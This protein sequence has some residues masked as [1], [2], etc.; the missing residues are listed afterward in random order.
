MKDNF[1]VSSLAFDGISLSQMCDFSYS[2]N[3][4]LE[5]SSN[6]PYLENNVE[7]FSKYPKK[8][9]IHI[10][11][12]APKNPFVINLASED[13]NI[14]NKS[15]EHSKLNIQRTSKYDLP[16]YAVHAGFCIDPKISSLGKLIKG[17]KEFDRSRNRNIF[18][19]SLNELVKYAIDF[20]VD[21]LI[22]NNVLS[23]KNFLGNNSKNIF[24]CVESDEIIK[25]LDQINSPNIGLLLDTGH[26]KVSSTSLGKNLFEEVSRILPYVKAVHHSDNDGFSDNNKAIDENYWFLPFMKDLNK[27]HHVLEVKNINAESIKT[28]LKI[29]KDAK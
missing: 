15:I 7:Y 28:Q 27:S 23:A 13:K 16:F 12:P 19:K 5:F 11:F 20:G 26:L 2:H 29:L 25:V 17:K 22:E 3:F 18:Y 24:L 8:K 10:Y 1:Y 14:L 21:L 9:L 6:L 4:N